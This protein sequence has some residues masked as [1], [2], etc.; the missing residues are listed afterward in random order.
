M[1][2]NKI[3]ADKRQQVAAR[4]KDRP[5]S[6][7]RE[8]IPLC[9]L[10]LE[11]AL[12]KPGARFV[13]ECKKAS[14][15]KGVLRSDYNLDE[16]ADAYRGIAD[17]VSV[18]ADEPYFGG[19]LDHIRYL[20]GKLD[21]PILCKDFVIGPYQIYEARDAGA[22]A[23]LLMLSVL[24]DETFAECL[25]VANR[26]QMDALC[27]VHDEGE[28]SRALN[29]GAKII[30]I[31][32][33]NL[34][35]LQVDLDVTKRLCGKVPNGKILISE[36]GIRNHKD[37]V[38][39]SDKVDAFLIGTS[40]MKQKRVDLGARQLL[41]GRVK[42]C[43]LTRASD[44]RSA[45]AAGASF[46]GLIF[47]QKSPRY[48]SLEVAKRVRDG[49]PLNWV[50]VFVN[51]PMEQVVHAASSLKLAAVQL[52][53]DESNEYVLDL[54][55]KL[56]ENCQVW[57]AISVRSNVPDLNEVQA[58][59]ILLDTYQVGARGGTGTSFN[60]AL[61]PDQQLDRIVLSGGLGP[62]NVGVAT[63][64]GAWALDANSKLEEEP[65]IKSEKKLAAFF[66]RIRL[67]GY[68]N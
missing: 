36:S 68:L 19:S 50:G 16:L 6:S 65:G 21:C 46:G 24:D 52:H 48:V 66:D 57:K 23:I 20:R 18:L 17:A 13:L 54:K 2:L 3:L 27:E 32:N 40:L 49:A 47:T 39:L 44:A 37:I 1:V 14:P 12:L 67:G 15:S 55:K 53:G 64:V 11:E 28:L 42:I 35:T 56:G 58:D 38:N 43:G 26:L 22:D 60:W 51:A 5:L 31:N 29:L 33:R 9:T 4:K 59:R 8:R 41:F 34:K 7:F 30:G 10:S 61:I 25:A 63:K 45:F 62:E